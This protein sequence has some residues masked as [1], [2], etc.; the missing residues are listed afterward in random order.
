M[1]QQQYIMGS[2]K[3]KYYLISTVCAICLG[4]TGAASKSANEVTLECILDAL[5][6]FNS[7]SNPILYVSELQGWTDTSSVISVI[8][9]PDLSF[10][11]YKENLSRGEYR[12]K[13]VFYLPGVLSLGE[14]YL[15]F[16]DTEKIKSEINF[17]EVTEENPNYLER[18]LSPVDTEELQFIYTNSRIDTIIIGKKR[19]IETLYRNCYYTPPID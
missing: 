7:K 4:C 11:E 10:V 9:Y 14:E 5:I 12:G 17:T 15:E 8:E 13:T 18:S 6:E 3:L 16:L 2:I 1:E 19:I